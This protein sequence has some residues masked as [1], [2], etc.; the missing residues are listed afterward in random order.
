[1]GLLWTWVN[2]PLPI[3]GTR[4][5]ILIGLVT[6]F[7]GVAVRSISASLHQVSPELE[8]SARVC[9]AR[10][11]QSLIHVAVPLARP[12]IIAGI[13]LLF[14]IFFGDLNISLVLWTS[15]SR[16][17][18]TAIM[19]L[20]ESGWTIKMACVGTMMMLV[21]LLVVVGFRVVTKENIGE[22][23]KAGR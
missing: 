14:I 21:V 20:W 16:M 17:A 19:E 12:G 8:W 2:I 22:I 4:W 10:W 15:N 6:R 9:G 1:M 11:Y 18:A 3:Y 13:V 7:M 5:I 23:V